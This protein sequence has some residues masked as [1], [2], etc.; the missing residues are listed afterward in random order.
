MQQSI[1]YSALLSEPASGFE[2]APTVALLS[3]RQVGKTTL[4]RQVTAA[5]PGRS[6]VFDL[7]V[8]GSHG[9]PRSIIATAGNL[10][11]QKRGRDR[12]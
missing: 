11:A 5:W 7:D 3:T 1:P 8:D 12:R 10:V 4:T 9:R 2:E 6:P